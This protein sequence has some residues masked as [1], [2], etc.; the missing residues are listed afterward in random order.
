MG[1]D[2]KSA[3]SAFEGSNPSPATSVISPHYDVRVNRARVAVTAAFI[4]NGF[5]VGAFV[6][7]LPDFKEILAISNGEI[8]RALLFSSLGILVALGPTGRLCATRGSAWVAVPSAIGLALS[9]VLV[10]TSHSLLQLTLTLFV[11]GFFLA[12]QDVSMN[13]HAVAVEHEANKRFMST[14]HAMFSAGALIGGFTGG[15]LSQWNIS[16]LKHTIVVG[17]VAIAAALLLKPWWM[18]NEIDIHP[19]DRN[20]HTRNRRRPAIFWALGLIMMCGQVGEGAAGDWGGILSR[21]TFH[22]S[23]FVSTLPYIFFSITMVIGRFLGDYL[24]NRFGVRR[25]VITSGLI[26]S[27]GLF[28]GLI[29]GGIYGV[30]VGWVFLAAGS[31]TVFPLVLSMSGKMAKERFADRMAPSEGMAMVSGI[32]YFGFLAGPPVIGFLANLVT[33]RW[34]MMVPALLAAYVVV[35]GYFTVKD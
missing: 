32:A 23:P 16:I 13:T 12:V 8:G 34:A 25:V 2:C 20:K 31:S 6:A 5:V 4:T 7:R 24:A 1:A 17:V 22:A 33:L 9:T 21:T 14:F 10:G 19:I 11:F 35:A 30:I 28:G 27:I 18:P 26:A 29:V 15:L 3:G